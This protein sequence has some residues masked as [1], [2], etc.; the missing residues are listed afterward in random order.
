[1]SEK[2]INVCRFDNFLR[3]NGEGGVVN[4]NFSAVYR[5]GESIS[6]AFFVESVRLIFAGHGCFGRRFRRC[7]GSDTFGEFMGQYT[8]EKHKKVN[9][10]EKIQG[11]FPGG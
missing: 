4:F 10:K 3:A 1:M 6:L 8:E 11:T 5:L 9:R 7:V 2:I